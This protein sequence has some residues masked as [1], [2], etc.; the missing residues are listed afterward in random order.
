MKYVVTSS[1][2]KE[3][4]RITIEDIGI[5]SMVLMERASLAVS[6]HIIKYAKQ[7]DTI[8]V[9]AGYGNNGGDGVAVARI[10]AN[11]NYLVEILM[12]GEKDR[13]TNETKTQLK[14]AENLGIKINNKCNI[15]EYTILVDAIFGIGL[16]RLITGM[17]QEIIEEINESDG[18]VFSIDI[19][20][21]IDAD[22]G[23]VMNVSVK[24]DYTITFGYEKIG[25]I[26]YPGCEHCGEVIV[27]DIGFAKTAIE[28]VKTKSF[29][30]EKSDLN[31]LPARENYSNKGNYGKILV[32]A[33]S[34]N[35]SGAC[36]MSSKAAY[37]SGAGLVKVL[38]VEENRAIIQTLLP[39]ALLETYETE[40]LVMTSEVERIKDII[41]WASVIVIGPGIG[42]SKSSEKILEVV[43]ETS[44]VPTIIDADGL[45]LLAL[46]EE[47]VR[48]DKTNHFPYYDINLPGNFILTPHM[49]EMSRLL[50]IDMEE[51]KKDFY[52][53]AIQVTKEKD[54]ILALKDARTIVTSHGDIYINTS[55]NNGMATGGS[56]D[57]LTGIIAGLISGGM[58]VFQ[59]TTLSVYLHG[60]AADEAVLKKSK[61]S[62]MATDIIE[63]LPGVL[64]QERQ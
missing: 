45:N 35:M 20:S 3:I 9:I 33:G 52:Q 11:L 57:V 22:T 13:A 44:K 7:T 32:I 21:G 40:K 58:D 54:F 6:E 53:L 39:E 59:A 46:N 64:C 4:D 61:Y 26:L 15:G 38:T 18:L 34:K 14:I 42:M 23:K 43:L 24:A 50:H 17:Y 63:A 27:S 16:S 8:L 41:G 62:L 56:G 49:K 1:Q 47:Y 5:P 48:K 36:F 29:V 30:Y 28:L 10:L 37:R 12:V 55:G 51:M 25:H 60:M 31:K 2:M 19:P